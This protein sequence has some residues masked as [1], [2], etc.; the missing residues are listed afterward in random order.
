[1]T[2]LLLLLLLLACAL[3]VTAQASMIPPVSEGVWLAQKQLPAVIESGDFAQIGQLLSSDAVI[4]SD[5][6]Q[7]LGKG[8]HEIIQYLRQW[9]A[10]GNH[11]IETYSGYDS[12]I[13]SITR[14]TDRPWDK[15]YAMVVTCREGK[16]ARIMMIRRNPTMP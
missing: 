4:S 2:R 13:I 3:P 7:P 16:I 8:P 14:E 11:V 6:E 9:Y 12:L 1:M 10:K 5:D 15:A